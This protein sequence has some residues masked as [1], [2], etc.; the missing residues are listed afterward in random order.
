MPP[1]G[2]MNWDGRIISINNGQI[3]EISQWLYE[4]P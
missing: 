2:E 3:S 4:E 1:I